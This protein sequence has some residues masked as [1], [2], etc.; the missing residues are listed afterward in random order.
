MTRTPFVLWE[1]EFSD[2]LGEKRRGILVVGCSVFSDPDSTISRKG[3]ESGCESATDASSASRKGGGEF[4]LAISS[5]VFKVA[6][7]AGWWSVSMLCATISDCKLFLGLPRGRF[8]GVGSFSFGVFPGLPL[9]GEGLAAFR[10]DF[11]GLPLRLFSEGGFPSSSLRGIL[12]VIVEGLSFFRGL[13]WKF[14][15]SS[16][17]SASTVTRILH[18]LRLPSDCILVGEMDRGR[19]GDFGGST[20]SSKRRVWALLLGLRLGSRSFLRG[21]RTVYGGSQL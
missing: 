1:C 21:V 4:S 2:S 16:S 8:P 14:S 10:S 13:P 19:L 17:C 12:V 11:R 6:V 15:F 18:G 3:S 20:M 9:I 7:V 5:S